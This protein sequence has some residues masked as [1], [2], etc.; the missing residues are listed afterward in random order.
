MSISKLQT[1]NFLII[2]D[3][4]MTNIKIFTIFLFMTTIL[5]GCSPHDKTISNN[6]P[7]SLVVKSNPNDI[8]AVTIKP[9]EPLKPLNE[10]P[11]PV[12]KSNK[13]KAAITPKVKVKEIQGFVLLT[14][15][16]ADIVIDL[17]YATTDNFTKKI[18]YP[19]KVCVLRKTTAKKLVKANTEL[20]KLGYRIKVWDGYRPVYVQQIFWDIVKDNRFVANPKNG[21]SIHNR[22]SAVDITLVDKAGK[23]LTMPSKFDDFS[24]NAYRNNMKMTA[25]AKKNMQLLT[26]IMTLNGFTTI[27]TE[28]WHFEDSDSKEYNNADINLKLFLEK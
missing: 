16:D 18:I 14:S 2:G 19:N 22:G 28:W 17:K 25:E 6:P 21:G 3:L 9:Q 13:G 4:K 27:S 10:T 11:K 1:T 8:K 7:D 12:D 5:T 26:N 15:L 24:S 23:E 20:K